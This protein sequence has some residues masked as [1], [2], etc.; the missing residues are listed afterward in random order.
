M[1]YS[2][3][4]EIMFAWLDAYHA[5]LTGLFFVR[6]FDLKDGAIAGASVWA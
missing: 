2:W 3:P 1:S 5:W 4:F 6:D